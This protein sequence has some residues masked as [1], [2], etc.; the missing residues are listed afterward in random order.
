M[1]TAGAR[2]DL[3]NFPAARHAFTNPAATDLGLRFGMPLAYDIA[4]DRE[5][6]AGLR[7]FLAKV[8]GEDAVP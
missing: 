1:L 8:F 6:W 5:S 4:A 2:F 3:V 7:A